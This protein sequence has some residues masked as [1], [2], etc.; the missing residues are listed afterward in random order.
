MSS[1]ELVEIEWRSGF[2]TIGFA[3]FKNTFNDKFTA[4]FERV[5]GFK[6]ATDIEHIRDYG[7]RMNYHEAKGFFPDLFEKEDYE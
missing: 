3:L 5:Y 7:V 6:E 2:N 1:L 4:R